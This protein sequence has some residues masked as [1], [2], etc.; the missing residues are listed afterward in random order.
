[1]SKKKTETAVLNFDSIKGKLPAPLGPTHIDVAVPSWGGSV[2]LRKLS[3]SEYINLTSRLAGAVKGAVATLTD[4]ATIGS[5]MLYLVAATAIDN[6]GNRLFAGEQI[7]ALN[8]DSEALAVL[9]L[10]AIRFN[11]MGGDE[12]NAQPTPSLSSD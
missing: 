11:G 10:A 7:D 5:T 6:E 3:A 1:M 2:R 4:E 9:G 12:G 8:R